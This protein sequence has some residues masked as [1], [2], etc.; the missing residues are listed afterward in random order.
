MA[1]TGDSRK[2]DT[3]DKG[4]VIKVLVNAGSIKDVLAGEDGIPQIHLSTGGIVRRT[5]APRPMA[6]LRLLVYPLLGLILPLVAIRILAWVA[7]G[8]LVPLT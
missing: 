5:E 6:Y 7:S 3:A 8:F 4:G 2:L 1:Y